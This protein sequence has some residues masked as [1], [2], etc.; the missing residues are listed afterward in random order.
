MRGFRTVLFCAVLMVPTAAQAADVPEKAPASG[1]TP[2]AAP[3]AKLP[4]AADAE[5][6]VAEKTKTAA[7]TKPEAP[8]AAK[9]KPLRPTLFATINLST[10]RMT[11]KAG[12][13]TL[14]TWKIS[15]GRAGYH[16]PRGSFRPS[17]S[18][19]MWHSRQYDGAPM[20][21]AVFF[22][23]GIATH[24]TT[25]T[26]RLGRPAS[27]GCIR[28]RTSHARRFYTLVHRHGYKRT[29]IV[30][31]GATPKTKTRVARKRPRRTERRAYTVSSYPRANRAI[32]VRRVRRAAPRRYVRRPRPQRRLVFPG[33]S[34]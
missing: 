8:V 23:K 20:P 14:H 13:K 3:I 12:G 22:N 11:V 33:D 19:K 5:T 1:E 4:T 7:L 30:V 34:N 10:Q 27:H 29:R 25:A 6:V 18:S 32:S 17:W 2:A 28:L 21:Y 31:T 15:S 16:T 9:K 26:Y 24:G